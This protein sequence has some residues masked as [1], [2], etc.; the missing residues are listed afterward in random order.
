MRQVH[1]QVP[2][3]YGERV[4]EAA[5]AANARNIGES[6][7]DLELARKSLTSVLQQHLL[8]RSPSVTPLVT[9]TLMK[10]PRPAAGLR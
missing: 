5:K 1:L 3:G 9:V 2:R 6:E 7:A 8:D 10:P 4:A